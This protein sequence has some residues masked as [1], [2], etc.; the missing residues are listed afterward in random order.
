[1]TVGTMV[2]MDYS[3]QGFGTVCRVVHDLRGTVPSEYLVRWREQD[4]SE[5][6]DWFH[7]DDLEEV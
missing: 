6:W 7:E 4:G 2:R 1:M 3:L 5:D